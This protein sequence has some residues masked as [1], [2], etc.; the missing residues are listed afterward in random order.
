M[1]KP[2]EHEIATVLDMLKLTE[3]EFLRMLPDLITWYG[4]CK[5]LPEGATPT[6]FAWVD[7]GRPGEVHSAKVTIVETGEVQILKGSA[8]PDSISVQGAA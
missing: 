1:N 8:H 2:K 4:W 3:D 5:T 7:D 6:G